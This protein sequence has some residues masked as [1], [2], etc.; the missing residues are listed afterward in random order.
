[1]LRCTV[2]GLLRLPGLRPGY[3]ACGPGSSTLASAAFALLRLRFF[4]VVVGFGLHGCNGSHV[5]A[6]VSFAFAA[7]LPLGRGFPYP[8][9]PA[10]SRTA[11]PP[12]HTLFRL[13]R[14]PILW[15]VVF[16]GWLT[17][18]RSFTVRFVLVTFTMLR[19]FFVLFAFCLGLHLPGHYVVALL[20]F[21]VPLG[22]LRLRLLVLFTVLPV[23]TFP[24]AFRLRLRCVCCAF[25]VPTP[26]FAFVLPVFA[27]CVRLLLLPVGWMF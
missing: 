7:R 6:V 8:I 18:L 17:F 19:S 15:F 11:S 20:R 25:C 16:P 13:P 4:P 12:L 23:V 3:V 26:R 5:C 10:R 1:L 21:Y 22:W 27:F 9:T 2:A 14:L 24:F